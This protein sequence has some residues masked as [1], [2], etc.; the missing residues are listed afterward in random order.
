[1]AASVGREI[2][3]NICANKM[4]HQNSRRLAKNV[5]LYLYIY[6]YVPCEANELCFWHGHMS[7][8]V[9]CC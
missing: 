9:R 4:C 1:M 8:M 2:D 5:Y 6:I 3:C 7:R